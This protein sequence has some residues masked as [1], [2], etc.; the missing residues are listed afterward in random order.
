[1]IVNPFKK[2]FTVFYNVLDSLNVEVYGSWTSVNEG[3]GCKVKTRLPFSRERCL[4]PV[5]ILSKDRL[6]SLFLHEIQL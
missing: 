5:S 3:V 2:A 4:G 6:Y 1:M